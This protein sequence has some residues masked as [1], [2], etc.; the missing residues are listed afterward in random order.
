VGISSLSVGAPISQLE[1]IAFSQQPLEAGS[2]LESPFGNFPVAHNMMDQDPA[3]VSDEGS[4][5]KSGTRGRKRKGDELVAK[6]AKKTCTE[7][8][9]TPEGPSERIAGK[10]V[11]EGTAK[12]G[13]IKERAGKPTLSGRVPLMPAHLAEGGYQGE[14]K[15]VRAR[16]VQPTKKPRSKGYSAKPAS[17]GAAKITKK[18]K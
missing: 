4:D 15:A 18:N 10:D 6:Q 17:K 14:K 3:K 9:F 1:S 16:K 2:N 11:G 5:N 7:N 12:G 8:T 13:E